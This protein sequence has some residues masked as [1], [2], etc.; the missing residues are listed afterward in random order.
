MSG[1][2]NPGNN[3]I[4][5]FRERLAE[6]LTETRIRTREELGPELRRLNKTIEEGETKLAL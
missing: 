5:G 1:T 4:V 6:H 3:N 2:S